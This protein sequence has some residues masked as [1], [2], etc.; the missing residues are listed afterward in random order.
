M[1]L[2]DTSIM[3]PKRRLLFDEEALASDDG[4]GDDY[5]SE[6]ENSLDDFIAGDDDTD[7]DIEDDDEEFDDL[8]GDDM[9]IV[10]AEATPVK[11][12]SVGS[13]NT[14][15]P[16]KVTKATPKATTTTTTTRSKRPGRPPLPRTTSSAKIGPTMIYNKPPGHPHYQ[17]NKFSLTISKLKGDVQLD[18]LDIVHDY[19]AKHA[20]KSGLSTEVGHRAHNLHIQG[21][22]IMK[23]PSDKTGV[24]DLVKVFKNLVKT[25]TGSLAGYRVYLKPLANSQSFSTMIG[26]IT[27][28]DGK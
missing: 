23:Y 28:D 10:H 21:T 11:G 22:F 12:V 5:E 25:H 18:L 1:K 27:K 9:E 4:E 6:S 17:A 16:T 20:V 3:S 15:R 8:N 24:A 26:Y 19:L 2:I 7:E 14:S 13:R